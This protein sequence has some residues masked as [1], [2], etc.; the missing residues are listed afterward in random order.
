MNKLLA[1]L[2]CS[3]ICIFLI[4]SFPIDASASVSGEK[5]VKECRR[6]NLWENVSLSSAKYFVSLYPFVPE[7][8]AGYAKSSERKLPAIIICPGGSYC[9]VSMDREGRDVAKFF[10]SKGYACFVLRYRTGTY[11]AKYPD[12]LND[13]RRAMDYLKSNAA[14]Y[15]I[16]TSKIGVIGFSAGGHL[17]AC[18]ALDRN[19]RYAPAFAAMIYP[20]VT[21]SKPWVHKQSR[22]NLLHSAGYVWRKADAKDKIMMDSL[23]IEDHLFKEM[24]PLFMVHCRDDRTVD[25]RNTLDLIDNA[26]TNGVRFESHIFEKG[27]HGFGVKPKKGC[28]SASWPEMFCRWLQNI[29][30]R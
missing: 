12:A 30:Y 6:I 2:Y 22:T 21:M 7:V 5:K 18:M 23:S 9:Y 4:F 13:C 26:K 28:D 10:K 25:C 14:L 3:G 1:L 29:L 15:N 8:T 27:G 19:K 24:P 20:V 17:S 11:A 16:D